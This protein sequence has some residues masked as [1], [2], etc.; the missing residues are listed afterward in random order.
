MAVSLERS[1]TLRR[2]RAP[3]WDSSRLPLRHAAKTP[4]LSPSSP[5][6]VLTVSM[7]ISSVLDLRDRA[8]GVPDTRR[9]LGEELLLCHDRA[10]GLVAAIAVDDTTLGPGLGG[11]RWMPYPTF[12]DAV[13]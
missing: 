6:G 4:Q 5:D 9:P 2:F 3:E 7:A 1:S 10:S 8:V 11:V 12:D 13:E